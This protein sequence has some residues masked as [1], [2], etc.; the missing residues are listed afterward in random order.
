MKIK[1]HGERIQ[2]RLMAEHEQIDNRTL[3]VSK[4]D[5]LSNLRRSE[6]IGDYVCMHG[7]RT[8]YHVESNWFQ[9]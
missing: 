8:Y 3:F 5:D 4:G 7:S 1:Y 2:I 9:M 6:A